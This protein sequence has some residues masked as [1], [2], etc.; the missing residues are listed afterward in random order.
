MYYNYT[1][2]ISDWTLQWKGWFEPVK[3]AGVGIGPQHD[4]SVLRGQDIRGI[5]VKSQVRSYRPTG[6]IQL[7]QVIISAGYY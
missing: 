3:N 1:L 5:T 2:R 4:V 7:L 6:Y